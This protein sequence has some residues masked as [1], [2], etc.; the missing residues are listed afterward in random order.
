MVIWK[1]RVQSAG[2]TEVDTGERELS[3][4]NRNTPGNESYE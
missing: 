3:G 1:R 2:F 4:P